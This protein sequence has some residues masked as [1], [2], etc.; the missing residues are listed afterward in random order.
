MAGRVPLENVSER[1]KKQN[2]RT[3]F[4]RRL[5]ILESNRL[6]K[7]EPPGRNLGITLKINK[8]DAS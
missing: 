6:S 8:M 5:L 1:N 4:G 7:N 2:E 3:R